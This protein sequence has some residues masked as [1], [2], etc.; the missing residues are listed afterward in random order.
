M[1][2]G[3][4]DVG[5][6]ITITIVLLGGAGVNYRDDRNSDLMHGGSNSIRKYL[7]NIIFGCFPLQIFHYI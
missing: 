2:K 1:T 3:D 6:I 4:H 7:R 5:A